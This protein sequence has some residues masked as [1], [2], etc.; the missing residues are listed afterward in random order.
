MKVLVVSRGPSVDRGA[1]HLVDYILGATPSSREFH[2]PAIERQRR[3]ERFA[4]M[5][6]EARSRDDLGVGELWVPAS[7]NGRRPAAIFAK[8]AISLATFAFECESLASSHPSLT[9]SSLH[10]VLALEQGE[11]VSDER[12]VSAAMFILSQIGLDGHLAVTSVHRDTP[13]VHAHVAAS[14]VHPVSRKTF[15]VPSVKRISF[16]VRA[17]ESAFNLKTG[18]GQQTTVGAGGIVRFSTAADRAEWRREQALARSRTRQQ[19][20]EDRERTKAIEA[21][22]ERSAA[23]ERTPDRERDRDIDRGLER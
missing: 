16:H 22:K 20:R 15:R 11:N 9:R 13:V 19:T 23:R 5:M 21:M 1:A 18:R 6:A 2:L 14:A 3:R 10:F 4:M 12:L 8:N 17:A 7:S